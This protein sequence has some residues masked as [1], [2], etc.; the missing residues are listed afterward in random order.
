VRAKSASGAHP[1]RPDIPFA[2]SRPGSWIAAT[3][4]VGSAEITCISLYGLIE[5]LTDASMDRSL[6]NVSPIFSDPKRNDLV[7]LGGDFNSS[8]A[9]PDHD[10]RM[11]DATHLRSGEGVGTG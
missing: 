10:R 7:L 4:L 11:R 3:V 8:T 2:N 5:E 9:W 1:R 6:S